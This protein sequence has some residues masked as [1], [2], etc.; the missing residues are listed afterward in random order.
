MESFLILYALFALTTALTSCLVL[1]KPILVKLR[2]LQPL[3]NLV[4]APNLT[5]FV[6][7]VVALLFAPIMPIPLFLSIQNDKFQDVFIK[8]V[9]EK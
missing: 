5:Y 6:F 1:L 3:N 9:L 2:D 8:T 7:F 4:Q